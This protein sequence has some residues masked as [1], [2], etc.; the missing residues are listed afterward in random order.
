MSADHADGRDALMAALAKRIE[1]SL[2]GDPVG[3]LDPTALEEARRLA[4]LLRSRYTCDGAAVML[5]ATTHLHRWQVLPDGKDAWDREQMMEWL[6]VA[7]RIDPQ[8]VPP[9]LR[10][11]LPSRPGR[12][13]GSEVASL[14]A[15]T[16]SMFARFER[17]ADATALDQ[18]IASCQEALDQLDCDQAAQRAT[19]LSNLSAALAV[20]SE[21]RDSLADA[22]EAA[23]AAREAIRV[24]PSGHEIHGTA[25]AHLGVALANRFRLGGDRTDL[26]AAIAAGREAVGDQYGTLPARPRFLADLA[27]TLRTSA[28]YEGRLADLDEAVARADE[29]LTAASPDEALVIQTNLCGVLQLRFEWTGTSGDIDRA[30]ELG[31]AMDEATR[32]GDPQLAGRLYN[33]SGALQLRGGSYGR[34]A[35]IVRAVEVARRAVT[36]AAA[37]NQPVRVMCLGNLSAALRVMLSVEDAF[38]RRDP[39]QRDQDLGESID[40]TRM[41][42]NG[43]PPG[44]PGRAGY[45][46]NLGVLLRMRTG[47]GDLDEAVA[48]ASEAAAST[49]VDDHDWCHTMSNLGNALGDRFSRR[50][51]AADYTQAL[52]AWTSAAQSSVGAAQVRLAATLAGGRLAAGEK[53]TG[54][55][56]ER[57]AHGVSLLP[58]VA[59]R[60]LD[61]A[62]REENLAR[63]RGIASEAAALAIRN[64]DPELAVRLLEQGRSVL[65]SQQLQMRTDLDQLAAIAPELKRELDE[66]RWALDSA[67]PSPDPAGPGWPSDPSLGAAAYR[68]QAERWDAL[69][70]RARELPGQTDFLAPAPFASLCQAASDGP[71]VIVNT[72]VYGCDALIVRA[73]GVEVLPLPALEHDQAVRNTDAMLAALGGDADPDPVLTGILDWLWT[74]VADPVLSKLGLTEPLQLG[75]T[76]VT[77]APRLWWCPT[78][79]LTLLPLHAAGGYGRN[80][81]VADRVVSSYTTTLGA[82]IRARQPRP[83]TARAK[84][85]LVGVPAPPGEPALPHVSAELARVREHLGDVTALEGTLAARANVLAAMASHD[86]VHLA[87]HGRQNAVNPAAGALVLA[88]GDLSI[89]DIASGTPRDADLA[90]LSACQT[91][92]GTTRHSDE[93][94]H[95]AAAFQIAGYRHVI[96]TLWQV[97][98]IVCRDVAADVY[99]T[100]CP[101]KTP[102]SSLAGMAIHLAVAERRRIAPDRP[103]AWAPYVHIGP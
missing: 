7:A 33:L 78:G 42:L 81:S 62:V 83:G 67:G 39:V 34:P 56:A 20:R 90:Y 17:T 94:I 93:A 65:W 72:S 4:G 5:L 11:S 22:D 89:L 52:A 46:N 38:N 28:E 84:Q 95:L 88:D 61:R 29:A 70:A 85:L 3:V 101:G 36:A 102:D 19:F 8:L 76:P 59:W 103:S 96:A 74:C 63:W 66:V 64:N 44:H 54:V 21:A 35:D 26:A 16:V 68:R 13:D 32:P 12:A 69:V 55:A 58:I 30:V 57:F 41:A 6:A 77:G 71:V 86:W 45:L 37:V 91:F 82:L 53:D 73:S 50:R 75:G 99:K 49:A 24:S 2:R 9:A 31:R 100:L 1:A 97:I 51:A 60:G 79:P 92:T 43:T 80:A 47:P 40:A 87:C 27:N 98:D 25:L 14:L 23:A 18:A 10:A 48:C 15:R